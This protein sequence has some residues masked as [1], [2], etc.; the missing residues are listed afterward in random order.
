MFNQKCLFQAKT[1][2][3]L[4]SFFW[5]QDNNLYLS[6]KSLDVLA[7]NK[8]INL[9]EKSIF[10]SVAKIYTEKYDFLT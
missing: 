1:H 7:G 8:T 10:C 4:T 2:L 3:I 9:S 5:K 6:R